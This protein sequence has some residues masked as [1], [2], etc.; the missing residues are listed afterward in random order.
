MP[1][2]VI[3]SSITQRISGAVSL[4]AKAPPPVHWR[5]VRTIP[6]RSIGMAA[7]PDPSKP[8]KKRQ[9]AGSFIFKLP[10]DW[11]GIRKPQ[12]ALF[13]R[14]AKVSTYQ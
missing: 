3:G 2:I 13:R 4:Q 6:T 8:L 10:Q 9:V 7:G 1:P 5:L 12:V 14:S 11:P